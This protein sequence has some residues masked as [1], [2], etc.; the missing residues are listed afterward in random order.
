MEAGDAFRAIV[1]F[2]EQNP[3]EVLIVDLEDYTRPKDTVALIERSGLAD[4]VY[5]G[6]DGPP[7]PTLGE[8][9]ESGQRLLLVVEHRTSGAPRWY[10]PAYRAV[11]QE[12]PFE[13][14]TPAQMSC[15][16]GRGRPSN[17]LFLINHWIGTDPTPK[18]SNA[19]KVNAY[20]FLLERARRCERKRGRFPNVLNV[21]FF[22]EGEPERVIANLNRRGA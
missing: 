5:R 9:I 22:A 6:P 1:R 14:K 21:D 15:V 17:S 13:F 16:P 10:R 20:D 11:F 18:P 2:L 7:W 3:E 19:A 8:M 4:Y 12:T